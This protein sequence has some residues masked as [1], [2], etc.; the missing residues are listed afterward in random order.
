MHPPP[1]CRLYHTCWFFFRCGLGANVAS[2]TV[3]IYVCTYTRIYLYIYIYIYIYDS[4]D[5]VVG[6]VTHYGDRILVG[7]RFSAPVQTSS[8]G[9]AARAWR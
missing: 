1:P 6:I 9:K 3:H 5:S 2:L 7:A 8:E 4:W